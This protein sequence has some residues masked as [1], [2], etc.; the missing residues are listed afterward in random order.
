MLETLLSSLPGVAFVFAATIGGLLVFRQVYIKTLGE[1]QEKLIAAQDRQ[2][3][4]LK[5]ENAAMR[6]AFKQLGIEIGDI[7]EQEI[8]LVQQEQQQKR[9][10]VIRV[11]TDDVKNGKAP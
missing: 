7:N 3:K 6:A 8:V 2:I 10:H 1:M 9:T 11:R 5:L 4:Q